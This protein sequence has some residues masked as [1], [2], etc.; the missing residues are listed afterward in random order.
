MKIVA[1]LWQLVIGRDRKLAFCPFQRMAGQQKV[2]I[3]WAM[4]YI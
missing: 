3:Y 4:I 2:K 1:L